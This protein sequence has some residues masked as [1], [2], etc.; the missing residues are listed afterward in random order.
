MSKQR[1]K[2]GPYTDSDATRKLR[3]QSHLDSVKASIAYNK[4]FPSQYPVYCSYCDKKH[5]AGTMIIQH[6]KYSGMYIPILCDFLDRKRK[7]RELTSPAERT[8]RGDLMD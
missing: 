6:P 7:D 8:H 5:P 1:K 4:P 2:T 3:K